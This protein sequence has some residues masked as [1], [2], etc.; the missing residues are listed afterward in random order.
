MTE[1]YWKAFGLGVVAGMRTLVA[2]A[3]LSHKL[4]GTVPIRQP[5]EPVHYLA[6]PPTAL[7]LTLLA[8]GE[9]LGDKVPNVPDRTSPPQFGARIASGATCGA[10]LSGVEG[11]SPPVGA[12]AGGLGAAVGTLA[13]F[14]LRR[15]LDHEV[16]LPDPLVA[17][18]EDA[19]AIGAGWQIV[20]RIQPGGIPSAR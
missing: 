12:V 11:A 4:V 7:A 10:L 14:H 20:N 6:Q 15:W 13:F 16:G 5:T 3:L 18:A 8:A 2:P 17:L 19:L 9:I 1:T